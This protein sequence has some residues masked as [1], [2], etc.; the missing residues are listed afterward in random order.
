MLEVILRHFRATYFSAGNGLARNKLPLLLV[1]L[2]AGTLAA[3]PAL[4]Q[5]DAPYFKAYS[6]ECG[7][8]QPPYRPGNWIVQFPPPEMVSSYSTTWHNPQNVFWQAQIYKWS[9]VRNESHTS[10]TTRWVYRYRWV[11]RRGRRHR[12]K[13]WHQQKVPH[14]TVTPVSEWVAYRT[15]ERLQAAVSDTGISSVLG[16]SNWHYADGGDV[17]YWLSTNIPSGQY[18]V[19]QYLTWPPT[20]YPVWDSNFC[21]FR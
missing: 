21:T 10:Y 3:T 19:K 12:K 4:S 15:S 5:A 16:H 17:N 6:S 13:V 1:A 14:T 9:V 2:L 20:T 7:T 8:E 18:K 11:R